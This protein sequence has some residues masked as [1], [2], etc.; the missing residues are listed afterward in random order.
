MVTFHEGP[1]PG[2]ERYTSSNEKGRAKTPASQN[3][4]K[5]DYTKSDTPLIAQTALEIDLSEAERLLTLLDEAASQFTFQT[6][7][8]NKSRKDPRLLCLLHGT[9][10]E[11]AEELT[12]LNQ[13][14][15]GVFVLV[16]EGDGRGRKNENVKRIRAV[17]REDDGEG[18]ALLL[19]PHIM[20]QSSRAHSHFPG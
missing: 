11:H 8:D 1:D 5:D 7:D 19:E 10:A 20:V 17:F 4:T 13:R 15:A 9:L 14:G 16:Q 12:P 18:K 2:G 6:F 3:K